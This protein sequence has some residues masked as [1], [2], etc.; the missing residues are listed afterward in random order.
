[1]FELSLLCRLQKRKNVLVSNVC[2]FISFVQKTFDYIVDFGRKMQH[3]QL[4]SV[5]ASDERTSFVFRLVYKL[6]SRRLRILY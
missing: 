4:N 3:K 6:C 1:M 5:F 2:Y